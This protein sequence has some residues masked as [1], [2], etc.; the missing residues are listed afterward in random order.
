MIIVLVSCIALMSVVSILL[1]VQIQENKET[2]RIMK[3]TDEL[4]ERRLRN[5]IDAINYN[6][7]LLMDNN[8]YVMDVLESNDDFD[9]IVNAPNVD[10]N[11]AIDSEPAEQDPFYQRMMNFYDALTFPS[12]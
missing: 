2:I 8:K 6:D 1:Y 5:V 9:M 3:T 7:K 12:A 10:L 11:E 4:N